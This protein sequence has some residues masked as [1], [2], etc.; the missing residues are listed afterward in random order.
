[1]EY[2]L[3]YWIVGVLAERISAEDAELQLSMLESR[4]A[5]P[6]RMQALGLQ[7]AG[8]HALSFRKH[9]LDITPRI[10]QHGVPP[11]APAVMMLPSL[12]R[13]QHIALVFDGPGPQQD[14]PVRFAGRVSKSCGHDNQ[15]ALA[16]GAVHLR[17]TQ[18][19]TNRQSNYA[20]RRFKSADIQAGDD[21]P[22]FVILFI[23]LGKDYQLNLDEPNDA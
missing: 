17:K 4:Q 5:F 3:G 22:G 8:H 16:H 20:E 12:R 18:V 10:D 11:G 13:G 14:I 7:F 1:M 2:P 19:I 6:H 23:A 9:C 21:G 15:R